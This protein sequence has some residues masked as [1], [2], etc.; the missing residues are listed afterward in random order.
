MYYYKLNKKKELKYSFIIFFIGFLILHL[1][2]ICS[3]VV[4]LKTFLM[5]YIAIGIIGFL[6]F[7]IFYFL[8][9]NPEKIPSNFLKHE[10]KNKEIKNTMNPQKC[11]ICMNPNKNN[12]A[13]C[14]Y[15][16]NQI[17]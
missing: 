5:F 7:F 2:V 14:E 9:Q 4:I 1:I 6:E 13:N 10:M 12:L 11:S 17:F 16:G 8:I 15:C 3:T